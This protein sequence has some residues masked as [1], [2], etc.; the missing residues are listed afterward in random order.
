MSLCILRAH[1]TCHGFSNVELMYSSIPEME[2]RVGGG[3]KRLTI[4]ANRKRKKDKAEESKTQRRR[5]QNEKK[6]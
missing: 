6:R 5:K 1:T 2:L 3:Y 4:E